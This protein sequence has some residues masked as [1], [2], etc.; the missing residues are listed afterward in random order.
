ME[1]IKPSQM[2]MLRRTLGVVFQDFRLIENKNVYDNVAFAMRVIGASSKDPKEPRP[3][4]RSLSALIRNE[5]KT[6]KSFSGGEQQRAA[7]ARSLVNIP[8]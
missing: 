2:P 4:Y 6:G 7:I 1:T 8:D 5:E 3:M